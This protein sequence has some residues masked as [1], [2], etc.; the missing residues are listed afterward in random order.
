VKEHLIETDEP[1]HCDE[2]GLRVE[3]KLYWTHVASTEH[4]TYLEVHAKRGREAL[5]E[6]NIVP[7]RKGTIVH[8]GYSSYDQYPDVEHARPGWLIITSGQSS[9]QRWAKTPLRYG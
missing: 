2:T 9:L 4:A 1:V 5:D 6:I 8:D 7:Q 3:G